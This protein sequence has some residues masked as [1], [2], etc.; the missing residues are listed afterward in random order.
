MN[1]AFI[2]GNV[3]K[4]TELETTTSGVKF[5]RF[6]VAVK[7]KFGE[8]ESDFIN[9]VIWR[10]LAENVAK[11][12]TKGKKVAVSGSIQT[13]NYESKKG[14]KVYITE[15]IGDEVELLSKKEEQPKPNLSPIDDPDDLPF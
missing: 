9:C 15:I 10:S 11:Y 6:T 1:R 8:D 7:R 5:A 13:R 3:V 4:D 12:L 14:E 2:I